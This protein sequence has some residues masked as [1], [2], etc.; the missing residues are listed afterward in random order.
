M[1]ASVFVSP[2]T[3]EFDREYSYIVPEEAESLIKR[4]M[5]VIVPFGKFNRAVEGYVY[6]L[7]QESPVEDLKSISRILD[8]EP[9]LTPELLELAFWMKERY[10]CTFA[11]AAKTMLPPGIG[12][13]SMKTVVLKNA[14]PE[15]KLGKNQKLLVDLVKEAGGEMELDELK[16]KAG[17]KSFS[18]VLNSLV[19]SGIFTMEEEYG[20]KVREKTAKAA[21][22]ARPREEILEEIQNNNLKRIQ[23]IRVLELLLENDCLPVSE[24]LRYADVSAGVLDTLKRNGYIDFRDIELV[25]NPAGL[26]GIARTGPLKPTGEQQKAIDYLAGKMDEGIFS[27]ALLHG[28]TGSGKTEVYL[29]LI[30]KCLQSGKQAIVLVPEISLTPQMVERFRSRFGESVAVQHSRLSLGERYDQWRLIR[31]GKIDVV[32]GARSAVFAPLERIGLII[33]DE[34]HE[35]TYKSEIT[36]KY[37]A[38]EIARRRCIANNAL[39]LYGSATPSVE[40]YYRAVNGKIALLEM[41]T[42]PNRLLLPEV[43]IVDMRNELDRGNRSIF[44]NLLAGEIRRNLRER[45]QTILFLN[46]RGHS[47]FVLCRKCGYVMKCVYCNINLTYHARDDRLICHYC[48]YTVKNPETCPQCGSNYIRHFGVGTQKVEEELKRQFGCSVIRMDMD[49]TTGKNSHEEIL[50]AFREKNIDVLVG[51]QMIAKG[52]DFP[53]VTLVG[54]LAA[55]SLLNTGEYN[56]SERTFQLIT[57]VAGRCGRGDMPGRVIV[58]A[59]NTEDFSIQAAKNHDYHA[60]YRQEIS[61]RK[62]LVYPPFTNI[63]LVKLRGTNDRTVSDASR[64][65]AVRLRDFFGENSAQAELYGPARSPFIR[66]RGNYIWRIIIK[67]ASKKMLVEAF[68]H[69]S[70]EWNTIKGRRAVD[71]SV[72]INPAGML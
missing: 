21:Y 63:G 67:C 17:F 65:I 15:L 3:R 29:Q 32:V 7:S 56:S 4:G 43:T 70:D 51:T 53:N 36:P 26:Q 71:L 12:I 18:R 54:V 35:N 24:I 46:R 11:D 44:S 45:R 52:H 66:L 61:L 34:E 72:D 30:Q 2:S 58:Q 6:R 64:E 9:V 39:L 23:Q 42:R 1:I 37:N 27:E 33:I 59:Y 28:V 16:A 22:L 19:E 68:A 31:Q 57:Q 47:T 60:F 25:R 48:G 40:T 41:N 69:I 14:A 5:R 38:R 8:E 62:A 50:T 20:M 10:V 49:T 55:D 13:K